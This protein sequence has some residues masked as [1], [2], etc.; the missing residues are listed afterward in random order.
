PC[1]ATGLG[2][3]NSHRCPAHVRN[4][5]TACIC[6]YC[7]Y[8]WSGPRQRELALRPFAAGLLD[9]RPASASMT[10]LVLLILSTVLYD[11]VLSTPEWNEVEAHLAALAPSHGDA[12]SIAIRTF[13]LAA[14]WMLFFGA[15][16]GVNAVM[17]AV[18][19][20][21]H[22]TWDLARNFVFTL[23]PIAIAYHLAHYFVY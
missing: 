6:C 22:S 17:I 5:N 15:Y 1:G 13:G 19:K 16:L 20:G 8:C 14:S 7:C 12:A 10:A 9:R 18:V 11:G 3:S 4:L 21:T 2:P 23:V